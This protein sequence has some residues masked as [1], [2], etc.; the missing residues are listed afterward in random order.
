M[1]FGNYIPRMG[2]VL[3]IR[4]DN[5]RNS[6]KLQQSQGS[7]SKHKDSIKFHFVG[8][9]WKGGGF[10]H[11]NAAEHQRQKVVTEGEVPSGVE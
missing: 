11:L 6:S 7:Q 5:S 4:P 9:K 1:P 3:G 8:S 2:T 10:C